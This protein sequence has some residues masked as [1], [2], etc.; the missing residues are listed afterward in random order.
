L[1]V[2]SEDLSK[3]LRECPTPRGTVSRAIPS[4]TER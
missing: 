2:P 4:E 1:D 3:D